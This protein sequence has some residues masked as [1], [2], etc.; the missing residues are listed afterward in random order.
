MIPGRCGRF[1]QDATSVVIDEA[2]EEAMDRCTLRSLHTEYPMLP[3]AMHD[4]VANEL[5]AVGF[6]LLHAEALSL[7]DSAG[8][9]DMER[10][11]LEDAV[12]GRFR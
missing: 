6:E 12:K 8:V 4:A 3:D 11:E 7:D 9:L 5:S 10:S 1:L 2:V